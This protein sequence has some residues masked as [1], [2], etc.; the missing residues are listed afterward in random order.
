M[1]G[2]YKV[3]SD[4]KAPAGLKPG[5][6]VVTGGG[7]FR[8]SGGTA[9]TGYTESMFDKDLTTYTF[10][11][12]YGTPKPPAAKK[13]V[14]KATIKTAPATTAKKTAAKPLR[15]GKTKEEKESFLS[16][17]FQKPKS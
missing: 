12:T 1:V 6:L 11:G 4:G 9:E 13:P 3:G 2:Y 5:D 15:G 16:N 8:I 10:K 17:L 7:T 14:A